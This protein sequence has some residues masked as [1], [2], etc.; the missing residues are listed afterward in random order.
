MRISWLIVLIFFTLFSNIVFAG[1]RYA[2]IIGNNRGNSDEISLRYAENDAEKVFETLNQVA[3]FEAQNMVI[4]KAQNVDSIRKALSSLNA[5]IRHHADEDSVLMVYY[6]GH[7]DEDNLHLNG[8]HFSLSELK[9]VVEGSAAQFRLLVVDACRSGALTKA[10]GGRLAAPMALT[11]KKPKEHEG[12]VVMT[13]SAAG[14]DAQESE[15]L[16]GSFFTHHFVSALRGSAD[17]NGDGAI[18]LDEL[19]R[20]TYAQT[21]R[22][23]SATLVGT[24]HPTF[25]YAYRGSGDFILAKPL[26]IESLGILQFPS[27]VA[28]LVFKEYAEGNV[29]VEIPAQ[30]DRRKVALEDGQY[31]V[32]GRAFDTLYEGSVEIRSGE[33]KNVQLDRL[34]RVEYARLV[35]KGASEKFFAQ[36]LS[37][38][39]QAFSPVRDLEAFCH[40]PRAEYALHLQYLSIQTGLDSCYRTWSNN[41]LSAEELQTTAQLGLAY[42]LD[43]SLFSFAAGGGLGWSIFYQ[44]F[45]TRGLAPPRYSGGLML[46]LKL[47]STVDLPGPFYLQADVEGRSQVLNRKKDENIAIDTPF[48]LGGGVGVG[49][50]F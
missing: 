5:R 11:L 39:Y 42:H 23:S 28:F 49:V 35:R 44:Q 10:K 30:S 33:E 29:I 9:N 19:Y 25:Q 22:Q 15:R 31:F 34:E 7:A 1:N 47:L 20:Y 6:S 45:E 17:Q 3:D 13:A 4:L 2:L 50:E 40:G 32:R 46:N 37:L 38:G 41:Y 24:Q 12:L 8:S 43:Y 36:S 27:Q 21:V 16:K 14:E 48:W 26:F 18:Q